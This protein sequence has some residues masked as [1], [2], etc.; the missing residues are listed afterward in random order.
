MGKKSP[1][2]DRPYPSFDDDPSKWGLKPEP[3]LTE[4]E[5]AEAREDL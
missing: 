1:G 5:L 4:A 2:P 3:P